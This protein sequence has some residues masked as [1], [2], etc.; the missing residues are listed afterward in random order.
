MLLLSVSVVFSQEIDKKA[1]RVALREAR[2]EAE[3][4]I[5]SDLFKEIVKSL[6]ER[7]FVVEVNKISFKNGVARLVNA[8][9]NFIALDGNSAI[10]QLSSNRNYIFGPNG[11]GGITVEGSPSNLKIVTDK[12]GNVTLSM[13]VQGIAISAQVTI[14]VPKNSNR[15]IATVMPNFYS[16]RIILNGTIC[17]L[18]KSTVFKGRVI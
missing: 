11:I 6:N 16:Q 1:N 8:T 13:S 10:V 15:A 18:D 5:Q 9:T 17:P 2:R 3:N 7:S 12:K 14:V 4:N